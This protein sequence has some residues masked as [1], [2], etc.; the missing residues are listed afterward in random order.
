VRSLS[1]DE[2][3]R[4]HRGALLVKLASE[5]T[6][7]TNEHLKESLRAQVSDLPEPVS[8]GGAPLEG[9][10]ITYGEED[11]P[12]IVG[13]LVGTELTEANAAEHWH[14]WAADWFGDRHDAVAHALLAAF[15]HELVR[16]D[17]P[18][19]RQL[20]DALWAQ[21]WILDQ[22]LAAWLRKWIV[23]PRLA[24]FASRVREADELQRA[25]GDLRQAIQRARAAPTLDAFL[26][27]LYE[28]LPVALYTRRTAETAQDGDAARYAR[29]AEEAWVD[30]TS[31]L[32]RAMLGD[33]VPLMDQDSLRH[34]L[35]VRGRV[36]SLAGEAPS[37]NLRRSLRYMQARMEFPAWWLKTALEWLRAGEEPPPSLTTYDGLLVA[38]LSV[39]A[40]PG[41][42]RARLLDIPGREDAAP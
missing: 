6:L 25:M 31:V 3:A 10:S 11:P 26:Q 37:V 38:S 35:W 17:P 14:A 36:Q 19:L 27:S 8:P 13:E 22:R 18:F 7:V 40:F 2:S 41:G 15:G 23:S 12:R 29:F 1:G 30:A 33:R 42:S 9:L 39:V 4:A 24:E 34:D 28:L 16:R 21:R 32:V 20:V 5:S